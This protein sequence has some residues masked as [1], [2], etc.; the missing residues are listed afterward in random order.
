[1][2]PKMIKKMKDHDEGRTS[3]RKKKKMQNK[4]GRTGEAWSMM[5][6]KR[7]EPKPGNKA[8]RQTRK[9]PEMMS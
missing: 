6:A 4:E 8:A 1:M 2:R 9:S 5:A 7:R 3:Q